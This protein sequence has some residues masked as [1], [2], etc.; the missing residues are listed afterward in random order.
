MPMRIRVRASFGLHSGSERMN[1]RETL[2]VNVIEMHHK[3]MRSLIKMVYADDMSDELKVT[4][5]QI[6]L[7]NHYTKYLEEEE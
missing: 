1:K 7:H 6:A 4:G 5:M 3:F 2:L